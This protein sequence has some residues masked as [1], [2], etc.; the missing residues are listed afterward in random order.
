[1]ERAAGELVNVKHYRIKNL[2]RENA[3]GR[4]V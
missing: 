2:K 1:M 4:S 3:E